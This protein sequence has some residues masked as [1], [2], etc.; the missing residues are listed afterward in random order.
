MVAAGAMRSLP[1]PAGS[2]RKNPLGG[3]EDEMP[4]RK[5]PSKTGHIPLQYATLNRIPATVAIYLQLMGN[6]SHRHINVAYCNDFGSPAPITVK[7]RIL[8]NFNQLKTISTSGIVLEVENCNVNVNTG[9]ASQRKGRAM[10]TFGN[11]ID[12]F[13]RMMAAVAFAESNDRETACWMM[14]PD[15]NRPRQ[16]IT[17]T[18]NQQVARQPEMRL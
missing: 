4:T 1:P 10:L 8:I 14:D 9:N 18:V 3:V 13:E 6:I 2:I 17:D 12:S 16:R 7:V 5:L 11:L 15:S